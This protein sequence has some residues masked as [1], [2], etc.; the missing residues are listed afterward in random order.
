[1]RHAE[2]FDPVLGLCSGIAGASLAVWGL[3]RA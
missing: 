2:E 3:S 1:M